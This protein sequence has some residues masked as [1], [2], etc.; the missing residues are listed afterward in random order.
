MILSDTDIIISKEDLTKKYPIIG[1]GDE[2]IVF[3]YQDKYA[4]K[5][6]KDTYYNANTGRAKLRL[7]KLKE[8]MKVEVNGCNI[9]LGFVSFDGN[10]INGIYSKIV[11]HNTL[12]D[13]ND[14]KKLKNKK[15]RA[16]YLIIGD[17]ILQRLHK[18]GFI[19]GDIKPDNIMIDGN[20][21]VVFIDC[22]NYKYQKYLFDTIPTRA[23][24]YYRLYGDNLAYGDNDKLIYAIMALN[25]LTDNEEFNLQQNHE[26]LRKALEKLQLSND[27]ETELKRIISKDLDK[28]YIGPIINKVLVK[29]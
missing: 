29:K 16:R 15:E 13:F 12:V 5:I 14:L 6:F 27:V 22:D 11:K 9:P 8:M 17:E 2:G 23:G 28:P 25:I 4:I 24:F 10:N 20:D 1:H 7:M 3:N 18:K 21:N 26:G 19:V